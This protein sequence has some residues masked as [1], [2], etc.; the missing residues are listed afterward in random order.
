M[1]IFKGVTVEI[2]VHDEGIK[3][4][5]QSIVEHSKELNQDIVLL[6]SHGNSGLLGILYGS[7]AQQVISLGN[8]PV[9]LIHPIKDYVNVK[10]SF[11]NF[12][13]PLDGNT[14]HETA[15]DYALDFAKLCEAKINLLTAI[16][17]LGN[18]S[19]IHTP[20]NRLLPSATSTMMDMI[21][22]ETEEYLKNIKEKLEQSSLTITT[23]I[24][25]KD[26]ESAIIEEAK[27]INADLIIIGTHGKKGADAFWE[28]SITPKISKSTTIPLLLTRK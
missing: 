14:E 27:N 19:G 16:P 5:S 24:S 23:K 26:P 21:V 9:L 6:C 11:E 22:T 13:V 15:L 10:Y 3:N 8:I 1:E 17:H 12:L 18:M 4:V 20:I 2:H 7:I 25:R 28:G